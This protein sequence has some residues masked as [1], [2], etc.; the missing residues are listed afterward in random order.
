VLLF[1]LLQGGG[2][3]LPLLYTSAEA[4]FV[5]PNARLPECVRVV[6]ICV[7]DVLNLRAIVPYI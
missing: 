5:R 2:I 6:V 4:S 3:I 7:S 1:V